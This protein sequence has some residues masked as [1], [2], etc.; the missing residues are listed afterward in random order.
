MGVRDWFR[1]TFGR[2][3]SRRDASYVGGRRSRRNAGWVLGDVSGNAAVAGSLVE[4]RRRSRDHAR[5]NRYAHHALIETACYL[6]GSLPQSAISVPEGASDRERAR[7]ESVNRTVDGR[8]RAWSRVCSVEGRETFSGLLYR[9]ILGWL[10]SGESF[11]RRRVRRLD[12]G[13]PVPLQLDLL[14]ADLVDHTRSERL[15]TGGWIVQGVEYSPIGA[16][17]A[18]HMWR[19]HPGETLISGLQTPYSTVRVDARTVCHL[20]GAPIER[21]GQARGVPWLH[22]VIQDLYDFAGFQDA[23]R[24]RMRAAA[25]QMA[26]VETEDRFCEGQDDLPTGLNPLRDSSGDIL[27][28]IRPGQIG[29]MQAGQ[30][31]SWNTPPTTPQV[32]EHARVEL[33]GQA[34]GALMPYELFSGDLSDTSYS[35]I[36][37]GLGSYRQLVSLLR[38][39]VVL[40][41]W[42]NP[43]WEWFVELGQAAGVLPDEAGPVR[44]VH[45][46]WP[47]VDPVKDARG[48]LIAVRGGWDT[49]SRV[50]A[51]TGE[52]PDEVLAEQRRLQEWAR[53]HGIVLDGIPS[54]ATL[55]GQVQET[56]SPR[57]DND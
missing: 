15:D 13:L 50:I 39:D 21:P 30:R 8:F 49:L 47:L 42:T 41:F 29:Y 55:G 12:D 46:P 40:P 28:R 44:W 17:Q 43:V 33:H 14:E 22:A 34:V 6:A 36:M 31:V 1:R 9:A 52:D 16:R 54:T 19:W 37:F 24:V 57:L 56:L 4:L 38:R 45:P 5:N 48:K 27:E 25:S 11:T 10:T 32:G 26:V 51:E 53:A 2:A 3:E 23:D 35:S 7:I 20:Y 18:Y